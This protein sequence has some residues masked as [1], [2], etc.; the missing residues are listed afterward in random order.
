ME[1]EMVSTE[2]L[3]RTELFGGLDE[4]RLSNLLSDAVIKSCSAGETIFR[5]GDKANGLYIL[6]K[7]VVDLTVKTQEKTDLM[8]S[9]IE[10]EGAVFGT[11]SLMEP[12][13]YNVSAVCLNSS[14]VL[15][16]DANLI[17]KK[18][19]EDPKTGM[20]IM[21]KLAS[22]YFIRLNQLRAGVSDLLKPF[23]IKTR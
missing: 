16:L 6:I 3:K 19:E 18:M 15:V 4:T 12:F 13:R 23:K 22:I 9:K 5:Q 1:S 7:G 17:R 10:K 14:E 20:E 21:K 11:A 8:T 2:W